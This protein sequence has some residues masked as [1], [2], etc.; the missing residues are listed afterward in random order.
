MRAYLGAP[1]LV[2]DRLMGVLNGYAPEVRSFDADEVDLLAAFANHAAIA[3]ANADAFGD[4]ERAQAEL[5]G[6]LRARDE[7]LSIASHEL[8]TP[9]AGVK[10]AAQILLRARARGTLDEARLERSLSTLNAAADRIARL[11][12]D[13]LD[14][15]RLRTGRLSL[16]PR[17]LDV[18]ALIQEVVDRGRDHLEDGVHE[19][20]VDAASDLGWVEADAGRL[21]QVVTNLVDNAVKYSPAGGT[22]RLTLRNLDD[23]VRLDVADQGIGLPP[24]AEQTIFEPFGRAPNAAARQVPGMGLGLFIC[25]QIV[26][27]HG[28][29]IWAE[30]PGEDRG[31]TVSIW[32]PTRSAVP[33]PDPDRRAPHAVVA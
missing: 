13:L 27:R 26:E 12:D 31:T 14:V 24:G 1:L 4:L 33:D 8:R 9:V 6:A 20:V 15:A 19:V 23:G 16:E 2:G 5:R 22:V 11:T 30:S 28:G 7:F 21:E 17:P 25:R 18:R 29:R 10:A 32:L 3:L